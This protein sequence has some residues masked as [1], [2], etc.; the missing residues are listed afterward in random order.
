M[1]PLRGSDL[2]IIL[3]SIIISSLRDYVVLINSS[4]KQ[5]SRVLWTIIDLLLKVFHNEN[6]LTERPSNFM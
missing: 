4:M 6:L 2:F 1:S 3:N 5:N